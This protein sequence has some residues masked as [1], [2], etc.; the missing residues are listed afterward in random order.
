[1]SIGWPVASSLS[2]RLY[3]RIGFRDTA[4]AGGMLMASAAIGF[5]LVPYPGAL[6]PLLIDQTLLGAGFG[7]LSTP[8]LVGAQ[9]TVTWHDRGVVTGANIFSR[10]LGQS[11]GA[12]LFGAVFNNAMAHQLASAPASLRG[13]LPREVDSVIGALES[14]RLAGAADDYLRH[15]MYVATHHVYAG[16]VVIALLT[17]GVVLLAPRHFPVAREVDERTERRERQD[18]A[19]AVGSSRIHGNCARGDRGGN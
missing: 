14:H 8:L 7:L 11:L 1:M 10:Y 17:V 3:L 13:I 19:L 15:A 5:L 12:A 6:L 18:P 4:L 2:G 16:A 9:N